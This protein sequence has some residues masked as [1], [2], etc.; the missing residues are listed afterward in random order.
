MWGRAGRTGGRT[1][2]SPCTA[3][4]FFSSY[5][6]PVTL[7]VTTLL[8]FSSATLLCGTFVCF[9]LSEGPVLLSDCTTDTPPPPLGRLTNNAALILH[10]EMD[11][12]WSEISLLSA[13]ETF[14]QRR[15]RR[16]GAG[17][18]HAKSSVN[19]ASDNEFVFKIRALHFTPLEFR[20]GFLAGGF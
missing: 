14:T 8:L 5:K 3:A 1:D 17:S 6:L 10:P 18:L 9:Q 11:Q 4:V 15:L 13:S 19:G 12:H 7:T 20:T 16:I 2:A